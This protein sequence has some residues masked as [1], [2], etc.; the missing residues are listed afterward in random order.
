MQ[1]YDT[2]QCTTVRAHVLCS[3]GWV[4]MSHVCAWGRAGRRVAVPYTHSAPRPG[5]AVQVELLAG[6]LKSR[7]LDAAADA[8]VDEARKAARAK[9]EAAAAAASSSPSSP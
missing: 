5:P 3:C 1:E 6:A 7:G 8:A 4:R 9:A 2:R